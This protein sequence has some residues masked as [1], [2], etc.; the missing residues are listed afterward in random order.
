[1]DEG[2]RTVEAGPAYKVLGAVG[3]APPLQDLGHVVLARKR[4][5]IPEG[6]REAFDK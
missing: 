5:V 6:S 1:M 2:R 4:E 3:T